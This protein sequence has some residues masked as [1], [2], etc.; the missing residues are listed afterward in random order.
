MASMLFGIPTG[1]TINNKA[2][3]AEQSSYWGIFF[4]DDW[5]LSTRLTLNL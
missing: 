3:R 5:R 1:G 4:Q 2:S